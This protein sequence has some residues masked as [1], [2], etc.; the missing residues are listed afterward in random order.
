MRNSPILLPGILSRKQTIVNTIPDLFQPSGD[1][2]SKA[3]FV[4]NFIG[5]FMAADEDP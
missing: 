1:H 5:K 3:V 4:K 2:L